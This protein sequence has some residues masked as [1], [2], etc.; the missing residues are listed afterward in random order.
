VIDPD[1]INMVKLYYGVNTEP[2]GGDHVVMDATGGDSYEKHNYKISTADVT[3]TDIVYYRFAV[4]DLLGNFQYYPD[5]SSSPFEYTDSLDCG[6]PANSPTVFSSH[7]GPDGTAIT[8][9]LNC[10]QIYMINVDDANGVIGVELAY[11]LDGGSS[12]SYLSMNPH[13]VDGNGNG[14]YEIITSIDTSGKTPP[15]TIKYKFKAKDGL[16]IW[17]FDTN[18]YAFDDTVSCGP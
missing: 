5:L 14:T 13:T 15:L 7:V 11:S 10:E 16:S 12:Y 17:T 1:G 2:S 4:I 3:G 6:T 18:I 8:D 9:P